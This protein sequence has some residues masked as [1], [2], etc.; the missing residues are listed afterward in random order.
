M[1]LS[2][3]P[4][5][6]LLVNGAAGEEHYAALMAQWRG[7]D[8]LVQ[9]SVIDRDLNAPPG[10]PS[11]GDSYIIGATPTGAWA[12]NARKIAR[13]SSEL[14]AWQIIT[15]KNGWRACPQDELVNLMFITSDWYQREAPIDAAINNQAGTT[16]TFDTADARG[17][18]TRFTAAT[19][20]AATVPTNAAVSIAVG[21]VITMRQ[22]GDGQVTVSPSGGV[23]INI[24]NGFVAKTARKGSVL[25][26]HKVATNE[27]DLTGDLPVT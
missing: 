24:P 17:R 4:N 26:L 23:T 10:S 7:F 14:V 21:S 12:G 1:A 20:I 2:Y 22:V 3:G 11:D 27:W 5:A 6:G 9:C 15:P 19:A 8:L 18:V 16:Y 25:M 13:W